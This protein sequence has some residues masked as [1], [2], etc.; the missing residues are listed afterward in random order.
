MSTE[1]IWF[2]VLDIG[3]VVS[4]NYSIYNRLFGVRDKNKAIAANRGMPQDA[5]FNSKQD[6]MCG[7]DMVKQTW[8]GFQEYHTVI[9]ELIQN[10]YDWGWQLL[11]EFMN[12]MALHYGKENVRLV[13]AFDNGG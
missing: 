2:G 9:G 8:M 12:T 6:L 4:Q 3:I 10:E 5:S 13:V 1:S 7:I 11:D